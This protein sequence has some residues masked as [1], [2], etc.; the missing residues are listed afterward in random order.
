[1][2][3]AAILGLGLLGALASLGA[4]AVLRSRGARGRAARRLLALLVGGLAIATATHIE[5]L[6][7]AGLVPR[8]DLPLACNIFW[9]SLVVVDPMA[10]AFLLFRPRAGVLALSALLAIDLAVNL[11]TLGLTGPVVAQ[12]LFAALL[13]LAVRVVWSG[14]SRPG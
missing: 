9:T 5:N 7:R 4:H 12:L 6:T 13:V 14:E 10:A 8:P 1:M 3:L 11:T 2:S